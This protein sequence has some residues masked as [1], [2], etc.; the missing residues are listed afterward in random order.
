VR[1]QQAIEIRPLQHAAADDNRRNPASVLDVGERIRIEEHQVGALSD[2]DR[3][4]GL[5]SRNRAGLIVAV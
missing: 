1:G 5:A 4:R 3:S 2:V